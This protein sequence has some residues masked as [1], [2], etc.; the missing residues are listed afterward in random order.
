MGDFINACY[1]AIEAKDWIDIWNC[2]IFIL[3]FSIMSMWSQRFLGSYGNLKSLLFHRFCYLM[4]LIL[5][6]CNVDPN[7]SFVAPIILKAF[8]FVDPSISNVL[9]FIVS[10]VDPTFSLA[11]LASSKAFYFCFIYNWTNI[12]ICFSNFQ[13]LH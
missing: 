11:T 9:Y 1:L 8:F 2:I 4:C 6:L 5:N 3:Y 13:Q 10:I 12:L 7:L